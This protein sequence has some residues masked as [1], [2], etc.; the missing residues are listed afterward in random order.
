VPWGLL[1]ASNTSLALSPGVD[2]EVGEVGEDGANGS[3][4][5]LV[6]FF[7]HPFRSMPDSGI[8]FMKWTIH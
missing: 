3:P 7:V 6:V 1:S 8:T 4:I 5:R 2:A